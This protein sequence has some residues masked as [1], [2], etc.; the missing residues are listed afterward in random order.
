MLQHNAELGMPQRKLKGVRTWP[1]M[2]RGGHRHVPVAGGVCSTLP[3]CKPYCTWRSSSWACERSSN[4]QGTQP[5]N[6]V[7]STINVK[8]IKRFLELFSTY[9]LLT[10]NCIKK[11]EALLVNSELSFYSRRLNEGWRFVHQPVD[12][13][14]TW[15]YTSYLWMRQ[16]LLF[17]R[18]S[19]LPRQDRKG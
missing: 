15:H 4:K 5:L 6:L 3:P 1:S 19:D 13:F 9:H 11:R 10:R 14:T 17:V 7:P 2:Q 18:C 8:S 16:H 12:R